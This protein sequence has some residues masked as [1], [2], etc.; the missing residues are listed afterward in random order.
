MNY[1]VRADIHAYMLS[2]GQKTLLNEPHK[3][4]SKIH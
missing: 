1:I 3:L 2:E 4:F